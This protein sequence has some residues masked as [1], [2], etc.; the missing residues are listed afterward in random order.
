M[1]E[2]L[3]LI[4]EKSKNEQLLQ[5]SFVCPYIPTL[6]SSPHASFRILASAAFS[7]SLN[8]FGFSQWGYMAE[9]QERRVKLRYLFSL[10]PSSLQLFLPTKVSCFIRLYSSRF[11][12]TFPSSYPFESRSRSSSIADS[13]DSP[14][15]HEHLCTQFL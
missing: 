9:D 3:L 4:G 5:I 6:H 11:P 10:I 1:G 13:L 2:S 7:S 8:P 15:L 12:V 14:T